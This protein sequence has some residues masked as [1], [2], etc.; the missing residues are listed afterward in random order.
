MVAIVSWVAIRFE[1]RFSLLPSQLL[2]GEEIFVSLSMSFCRELLQTVENF[3]QHWC[4][5]KLTRAWV[6]YAFEG[7]EIFHWPEAR[8]TMLQGL[9]RVDDLLISD[10]SFYSEGENSFSGFLF[11]F[12]LGKTLCRFNWHE[13]PVSSSFLLLVQLDRHRRWPATLLLSS[14]VLLQRRSSPPFL[15]GDSNSNPM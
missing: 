3:R 9:A 11:H 15:A 14:W 10:N 2:S 12:P 5:L 7:M 8:F 4:T 1:R 13:M 6:L